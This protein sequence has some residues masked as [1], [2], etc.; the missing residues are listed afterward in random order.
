MEWTK[1]KKVTVTAVILGAVAGYQF[2]DYVEQTR[3]PIE[4]EYQLM[5]NCIGNYA[6]L[7]KRKIC[8]CALAKAIN[9]VGKGGGEYEFKQSF[10][11][12]YQRCD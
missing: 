3:F 10:S 7:E 12:Y 4:V 2:N 8:A 5:S 9:T 1:A 11:K 6:T